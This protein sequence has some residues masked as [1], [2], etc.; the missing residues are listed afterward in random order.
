MNER[1]SCNLSVNIRKIGVFERLAISNGWRTA[2]NTATRYAS[3]QLA[4]VPE[5]TGGNADLFTENITTDVNW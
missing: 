3:G 5:R 4:F 1:K 2:F